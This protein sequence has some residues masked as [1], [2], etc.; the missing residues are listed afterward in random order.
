MLIVGGAFGLVQRVVAITARR[1]VA[2]GEPIDVLFVGLD[3]ATILVGL[4]IR[5][6]R[7]WIAA[8]NLVALSAFLY[9]TALPNAIA[10]FYGLLYGAVL[11]V[12]LVH[13][14]WFDALRAWRARP[15]RR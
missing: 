9:L 6:G 10:L 5:T 2:G 3:L 8:L 12:L 1:T 14:P 15:I 13:R 4:L 7:G 11:V